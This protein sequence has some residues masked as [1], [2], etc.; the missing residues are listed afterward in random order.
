M[1]FLCELVQIYT[2]KTERCLSKHGHLQPHCYLKTRS[3]NVEWAIAYHYLHYIM[4]MHFQICMSIAT[5]TAMKA[6]QDVLYID[7]GGSFC[8]TRMKEMLQGWNSSLDDQVHL[9]SSLGFDFT[10]KWVVERTIRV[11]S[12]A[13]VS[14][15]AHYWDFFLR[16]SGYC[17]SPNVFFSSF[18]H[19]PTLPME[20]MAD[21][22]FRMVPTYRHAILAV[23]VLFVCWLV[24]L[25]CLRHCL[26]CRGFK[27]NSHLS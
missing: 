22:S 1:L 4:L 3:L 9:W 7:T 27:T 26:I 23:D 21:Y 20:L 19:F 15:C 8:G 24:G 10:K 6:K 18:F 2:R 14:F 16:T 13:T 25:Y 12:H 17:R 11:N 5:F